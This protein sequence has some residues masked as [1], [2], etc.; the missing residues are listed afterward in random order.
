ME[1]EIN[2]LGVSKEEDS[3]LEQATRQFHPVGKKKTGFCSVL[4]GMLMFHSDLFA[5]LYKSRKK[6]REGWR[7]AEKV[8]ELWGDAH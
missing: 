4:G 3:C 1:K 7:E 8:G 6:G 5:N 2:H